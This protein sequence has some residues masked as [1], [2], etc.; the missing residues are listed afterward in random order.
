MLWPI[1]Y[2]ITVV[3]AAL[4]DEIDHQKGAQTL[5]DLWHL[6][7]DLCWIG[8]ALVGY[9]FKIVWPWWSYTMWFALGW[10]FWEC[11]YATA[12]RYRFH[13]YDN[14]FEIPF[15]RY[16]WWLGFGKKERGK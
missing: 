13:E 11:T 8:I 16:L 3:I 5:Y 1:I 12:K 10:F 2:L 14:K 15:G 9:T 7:R 6:L 4:T